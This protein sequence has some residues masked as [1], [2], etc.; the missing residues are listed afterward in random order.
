MKDLSRE[1]RIYLALWRKAQR[2]QTPISFKVRDKDTGLSIRMAMYR[3]IKPYRQGTEIDEELYKAAQNFVL[4][5]KESPSRII[6]TPRVTA[7]VAY[8]RGFALSR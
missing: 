7:L 1:K 6:I 3:T 4:V 5:T 8:G 2:E